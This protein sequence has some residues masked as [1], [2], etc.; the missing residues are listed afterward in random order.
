MKNL[1]ELTAYTDDKNGHTNRPLIINKDHIISIDKVDH[2]ASK[3]TLSTGD[4]YNV[5]GSPDIITNQMN[6]Q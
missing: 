5:Y 3:I 4:T 2:N 6:R 1:I